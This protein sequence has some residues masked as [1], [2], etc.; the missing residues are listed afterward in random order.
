MLREI[1]PVMTGIL[2]TALISLE[3]PAMATEEV[4]LL[5]DQSQIITLSQVPATLLVGN[6]AIANVTT[7]GRSLF[8]H[9]RAYGLTNVVA[10]DAD[11]NK[12]GEYLVRVIYQDGY[13]V[14]MYS[15]RGR[16]TYTCLKDCEPVLRLGDGLDHFGNFLAET[17]SKNKLAIDQATAD[18]TSRTPPTV[19]STT[20]Y[21]GGPPQ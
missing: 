8:L 3:S 10:L 12:L 14:S 6:P 1:L 13:G 7:D 19:N 11:G 21:G 9:P 5:A 4:I 2:L 15:P 18:D 16:E 20:Y 17:L